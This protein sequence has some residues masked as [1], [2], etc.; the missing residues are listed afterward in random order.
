MNGSDCT[1]CL[2]RIEVVEIIAL[3][4]VN[5]ELL[6]Q[7]KYIGIAKKLRISIGAY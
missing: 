5:A 7:P 3:L 6:K 2:S 1:E 4:E